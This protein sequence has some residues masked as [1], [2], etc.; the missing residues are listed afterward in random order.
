MSA[1]LSRIA[2]LRDEVARLRAALREVE[3]L[4]E[5]GALEM[6][7]RRYRDIHRIASE[8]WRTVRR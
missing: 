1:E 4:A 7:D 3:K 6:G 2:E 8:P 5:L